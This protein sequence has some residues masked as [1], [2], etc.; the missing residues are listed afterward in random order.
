[1]QTNDGT[2]TS[3]RSKAHS[4]L[5]GLICCS[6]LLL[7]GNVIAQNTTKPTSSSDITATHQLPPHVIRRFGTPPDVPEGP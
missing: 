4:L 2:A 6:A 3:L 7:S 1:M 5:T